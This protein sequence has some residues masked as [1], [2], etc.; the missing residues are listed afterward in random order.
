MADEVRALPESAWQAHPTGYSGNRAVPLVSVRGEPNDLFA[1]PMAA[2]P[3]LKQS[4]YLCQVLASFQTVFGRS[5]LMGLAGGSEVPIHSDVNYHW[6]SRV[7]IHVPIITYP[8]VTFYCHDQAMHMA[9]GEA[10]VFDNWKMHRVVNPTPHFRVHLV[11]DTVGSSPFWNMIG[12]SLACKGNALDRRPIAFSPAEAPK[13]RFERVNVMDVMHPVEMEVLAEDLLADLMASTAE[14]N[15]PESVQRFV[16]SVR[17]FYQ[18]WKTLWAMFGTEASGWPLYER[19]RNRALR[20]L[21]SI[22]T[23]LV[24]HSTGVAA[25][26]VMKARVLGSCLSTPLPETI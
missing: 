4:P 22:K 17:S 2:T 14:N 21:Y 26:P 23:P 18:D 24:L 9:G 5:R 19:R 10:W 8:E 12:E 15:T 25:V 3:W 1:G 20:E 13:L 16:S 7:R 11:A 6:Y